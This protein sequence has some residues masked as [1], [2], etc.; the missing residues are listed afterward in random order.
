MTAAPAE[1]LLWRIRVVT[2]APSPL[3]SLMVTAPKLLLSL[4]SAMT[5]TPPTWLSMRRVVLSLTVRAPL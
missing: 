1:L 2:L 4:S 5:P 3:V